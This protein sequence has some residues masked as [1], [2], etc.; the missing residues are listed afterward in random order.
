MKLLTALHMMFVDEQVLIAHHSLWLHDPSSANDDSGAT[1]D[2]FPSNL[3]KETM[4]DHDLLQEEPTPHLL[5]WMIDD[6]KEVPL[7]GN[8]NVVL[9]SLVR[10]ELFM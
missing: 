1:N 3:M 2:R 5:L 10:Q 7:K 6:D 9:L 4:G 8:N